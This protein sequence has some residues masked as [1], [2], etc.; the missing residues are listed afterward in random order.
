MMD[1]AYVGSMETTWSGEAGMATRP[2]WAGRLLVPA[3][4]LVC[5]LP[6]VSTGMALLAGIA[7][8]LLAGNPWL[9]QTRRA[10]HRLLAAA[11]VGLGA[12]MDLRAVVRVGAHGFGYT[13]VGVVVCLAVGRL[14]RRVLRVSRPVGLLIT[15][16]TAICG[17][18]AIAAVVPVLRPREHDVSVALVTVFLLNGAALFLFPPIGHRLALSPESFGLWS[19]LAIH[20]TSSVVGAAVAYG[21][22][23]VATAT[24]V[25]LARALFIVPLTLGLALRERRATPDAARTTARP[26]FIAGFVATAALVTFVP[27]LRPAGHVLVTLAHRALVVTLFLVGANLTREAMRAVG[28][29]PLA[30]GLLLWVTM[31]GLTLAAIARHLIA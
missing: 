2:P 31:A 30:L 26:W 16:G 23:A 22:N 4:A 25:K 18:S 19:A 10:T 8:A 5:L 6:F 11:V 27:A 12:G 21:G 3:G 24:T 20:D 1:G 13:V 14:L 15:V 9:A 29:R 7:V 28:L 17:G